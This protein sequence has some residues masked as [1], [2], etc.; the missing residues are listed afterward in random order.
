MQTT[1]FKRALAMMAQIQAIISSSPAGMQQILMGQLGPYKSRGHGRGL[2]GKNYFK[3]RSKYSPH[4]SKRECA[5]RVLQ[6][7]KA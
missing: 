3:S 7:A 2:F 6:M 4:Q 1:P 5:R